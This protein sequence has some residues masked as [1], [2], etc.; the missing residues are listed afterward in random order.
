MICTL[1]DTV[2][3]FT[4]RQ[5]IDR[6]LRLCVNQDGERITFDKFEDADTINLLTIIANESYE[7]FANTLQKEIEDE[8]G[9]KFALSIYEWTIVKSSEKSLHEI[10]KEK[11][12][13][14]ESEKE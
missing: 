4:K 11:M 6:G 14:I 1:I 10:R 12:I 13:S 9:V 8:T 2:D 7:E 5:K 3:I